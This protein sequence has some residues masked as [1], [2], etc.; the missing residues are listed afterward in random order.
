MRIVILPS[1]PTE[2]GKTTGDPQGLGKHGQFNKL[3]VRDTPAHLDEGRQSDRIGTFRS[4]S[5]NDKVAPI[6]AVRS[7]ALVP[8][9]T[10]KNRC[11]RPVAG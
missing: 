2:A 1:G 7:T 3:S 5:G 6:A 4:A 11:G 10:L 8:R 9:W